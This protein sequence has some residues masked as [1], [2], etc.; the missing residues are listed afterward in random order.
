VIL[1]LKARRRR[2]RRVRGS[3][4][5][6]VAGA[7]SELLDHARDLGHAV[8]HGHTRREQA[9]LVPAPHVDTLARAADA[10]VFGPGDPLPEHISAYWKQTGQAERALA[11]RAGAWRRLRAALS[12]RS[13]R[14]QPSV[15]PEPSP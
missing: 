6:R 8:P 5:S 4:S 11:A 9:E 1:G 10:A 14:A 2:R 7:W 15:S 3:P 12:L 13:L